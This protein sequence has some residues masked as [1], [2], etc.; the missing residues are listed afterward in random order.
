VITLTAAGSTSVIPNYNVMGVAKAAL[1]ACVRYL[2][3]DLGSLKI[4]VNGICAGP[5]ST[6][7][8]RAIRGFSEMKRFAGERCPLKRNIEGSEVGAA[9]VFLSS[10]AS[11]GITGEILHVDAGDHI[12]G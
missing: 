8:S 4:R 5:V 6:L 9:A 12:M 10:N 11:L 3:Y 2:A 1:D 7:S